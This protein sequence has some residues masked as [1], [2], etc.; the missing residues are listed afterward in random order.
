MDH[1]NQDIPDQDESEAKLITS[2]AS[3]QSVAAS[4]EVSGISE[5]TIYA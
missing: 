5:R 2:L 4:A 3:G 1:R